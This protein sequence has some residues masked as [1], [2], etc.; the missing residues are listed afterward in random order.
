MCYR[1]HQSTKGVAVPA[2][3]AA[4]RIEAKGEISAHV[5]DPEEV[6]INP[7]PFTMAYLIAQ[8]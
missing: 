4:F 7:E 1:Q 2:A 5:E 6:R 8:V 3:A